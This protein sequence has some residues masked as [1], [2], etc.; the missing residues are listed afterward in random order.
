MDIYECGGNHETYP[1]QGVSG[2]L[3]ETLWRKY[4]GKEP[5]Y[6]FTWEDYGGPSIMRFNTRE[7]AVK[8]VESWAEEGRRSNR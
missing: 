2:T 8:W 3:N 7:E 5:Y 1:S 4:T 6:S